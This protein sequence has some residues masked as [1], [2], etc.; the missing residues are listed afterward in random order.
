[1]SAYRSLDRS[2]E[3]PRSFANSS[4]VSEPLSDTCT[5]TTKVDTEKCQSFVDLVMHTGFR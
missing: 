4:A 3:R 1:M 5:G 2:T